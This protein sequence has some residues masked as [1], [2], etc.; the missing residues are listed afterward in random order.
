M[1]EDVIT[2]NRRNQAR[3]TAA[4]RP[5][6]GAARKRTSVL[7]YRDPRYGFTVKLPRWWRCYTSVKRSSRLKDAEYGVFFRFK[8]KGK[9]YEDALSLLVYK[10]SLKQWH[11]EGYAE[12]PIIFLAYRQGR[13]FAYTVPEELPDEFL[14]PS[15]DDYDYRKYGKPIRLLKRMVNEDVPKIARTFRLKRRS[16]R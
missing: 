15:K 1:R 9:I 2:L 3:K 12:S 10:M 11:D 4:K 6:S 13:I 14:N 16:S 8:Y 7:L 5:P